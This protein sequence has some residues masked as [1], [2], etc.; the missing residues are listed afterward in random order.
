ML[1]GHV[2]LSLGKPLVMEFLGKISKIQLSWVLIG[3]N[4]KVY[5]ASQS[6]EQY[7][8]AEDVFL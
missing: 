7:L 5:F 1:S 4:R 6:D 3:D 8:L 2:M